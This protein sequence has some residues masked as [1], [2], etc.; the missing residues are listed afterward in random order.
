V[1]A[2]LSCCCWSFR[3]SRCAHPLD[4]NREPTAEL[5]ELEPLDEVLEEPTERPAPES[6]TEA[7]VTVPFDP[8]TP[9]TTTVSPGRI[10][11]CETGIVLETFVTGVSLT[12][13]VLPDA[14]SRSRRSSCR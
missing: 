9:V 10:A 14:R 6:V 3:D 7:A 1:C 13:T 8:V 12:F 4:E 2:N 11:E 5:E